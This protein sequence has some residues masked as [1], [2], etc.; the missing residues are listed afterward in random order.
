MIARARTEQARAVP[1]DDPVGV[2]GDTRRAA[3]GARRAARGTRGDLSG[4]RRC[5]RR[6]ASST[7]AASVHVRPT[8]RSVCASL[9]PT[10]ANRDAPPTLAGDPLDERVVRRKHRAVSRFEA[11]HLVEKPQIGVERKL[12]PVEVEQMIEH[13]EDARL[14][15]PGRDLE[16]VAAKRLQLAVQPLVD[17][18]DAEVDLDVALRQPARHFLGDEEIPRRRDCG[19]GTRDSRQSSRGR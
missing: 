16:H 1:G 10:I 18:V 8:R 13:E 6:R 17:P 9:P 4:S 3:V 2:A 12:T 15:Q 11:R 19:R 14:A 7:G 5:R